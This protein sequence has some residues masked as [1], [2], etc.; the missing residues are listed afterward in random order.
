MRFTLSLVLTLFFCTLLDA[1]SIGSELYSKSETDDVIIENGYNR[2]GPYTGPVK[3][4]FNVSNLVYYTRII[5]KK[6]SPIELSINFTTDSFAIPNSPDTFVKIFLASDSMTLDKR[7]L[8]NY[9][10]R[11]LE[12]FD[13][14][15]ELKRKL[16]TNQD[17]LF[18]V[19]AI[20]Y[21]TKESA[22]SQERGGNR[23]EF[24][25]KGKDIYFNMPPQID[26]LLVGH[27]VF[28]K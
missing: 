20:F 28:D 5:N 6:E 17:C 9:G 2:G 4:H 19:V 10:V 16:Y 12:S 13:Q 15:T 14:P 25:L 22:W 23:S 18:N 3:T 21:Q 8:F 11:D 1:Q 24:A 7:H 27:I 26:S